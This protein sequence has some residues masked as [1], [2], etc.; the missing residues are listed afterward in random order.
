MTISLDALNRDILI[1]IFT[2]LS[3]PDILHL[4][5][6][7]RQ[8][9]FVSEEHAVWKTACT[10]E[11]LG[12]GIPFP[13]CLLTSFSANDLERQ[14][15]RAY[16]LG[17]NWR[18]PTTAL[19]HVLSFPSVLG[20][21]AQI[22]FFSYH[23][24]NW[25]ITT[26]IS[27][28]WT[29]CLRDCNSLR[30][31]TEWNPGRA[32]FNGFAVNTDDHSDAAIAVSVHRDGYTTVEILAISDDDADGVIIQSRRSLETLSKPIALNGDL[33][34][35]CDHDSETLILNW[36]TQEQALL[37]SPDT[38]QDKPLHVVFTHRAI[39]VARARSIC[40]FDEPQMVSPGNDLNITLPRV[41][42]SFGWVDGVALALA[43][44]TPVGSSQPPLTLLVRNKG[45]DPWRPTE[46]FQFM[47]LNRNFPSHTTHDTASIERGSSASPFQLSSSLSSH[48]RGLIR[49]R[50]MILGPYGT[51]VWTQPTDW[52]AGGLITDSGFLEAMSMTTSRQTLVVA[53]FPGLLNQGSS[54]AQIKVTIEHDGNDWSCLDY[55]EARG[56]VALG[57]SSGEVTVYRL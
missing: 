19:H 55:D 48:Q 17:L 7:S 50:D 44:S 28:W 47:T 36:K 15:L 54:E 1:C 52:A 16:K 33:L 21:V 4:R 10:N 30:V 20:P 11:I 46:Q 49:C 9:Y 40:I 38:W 5:Q 32:L 34:A 45:D 6:A 56:L 3:I 43:P 23:G 24:R 57:S 2:A 41:Y 53:L 18:S 26:S 29:L 37:K 35:L 8:L 31:V 25:I 27:I 12:H 39:F 14:T 22:K 13:K 42:K 51:A